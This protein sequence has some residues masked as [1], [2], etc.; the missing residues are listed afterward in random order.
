MIGRLRHRVT[1][2]KLEVTTDA[3]GQQIEN[4][5]DVANVWASVEP[6]S[7]KEYFRV[8]QINSEIRVK[9]IIRYLTGV[10]SH[11]RIKALKHTYNILSVINFEERNQYLELMCSNKVGE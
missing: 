1:L 11:M 9:I 6:L 2:Q 8:Q 5:I 10:T 4:W 7:G 3:I